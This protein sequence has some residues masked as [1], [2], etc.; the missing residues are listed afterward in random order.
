MRKADVVV[1]DPITPG[2]GY[3]RLD[4]LDEAEPYR[5]RSRV[6]ARWRCACNCDAET[7]VRADHLKLGS[8]GICGC[9]H[10]EVTCDRLF[11]H[12][13]RVHTRTT[14]GYHLWRILRERV[15]DQA[16]RT[17]Q[18][19]PAIA[20]CWGTHHDSASS[21]ATRENALHDAA[22]VPGT[23]LGHRARAKA[24][25]PPRNQHLEQLRRPCGE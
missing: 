1:R 7:L 25:T 19:T 9:L 16:P 11:V 3:N 18:H 15:H 5:W 12:R 14:P 8:V 23:R 24:A 17:W 13:A 21:N 2:R 22:G 6:Y 20:N 10:G 4:V